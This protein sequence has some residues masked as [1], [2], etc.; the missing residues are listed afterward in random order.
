MADDSS[1]PDSVSKNYE[2]SFSN[3]FF[4]PRLQIDYGMVKPGFYFQSNEVIN[5]LSVFGGAG[6]NR[7]TD[8]DLFLLFELR[9]LYPTLYAE[10]FFMTRHIT[11]QSTLWDVID[12]DSDVAYRLFQMEG[13]A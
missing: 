4:F 9:T 1:Y 11:N 13:G 8:L 2:D 10:I 12:I 3:M 5:R 7:L 6:I